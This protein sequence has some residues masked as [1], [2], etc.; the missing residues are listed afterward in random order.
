LRFQ[1]DGWWKTKVRICGLKTSERKKRSMD[2]FAGL[3]VLG[4]GNKRLRHCRMMRVKIVAGSEGG[5]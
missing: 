1:A 4:Q 3:D 5:K 2:Y